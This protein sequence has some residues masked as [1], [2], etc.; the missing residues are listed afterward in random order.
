MLLAK[1]NAAKL[2]AAKIFPVPS[3]RLGVFQGSELKASVTVQ[4]KVLCRVS[5][6]RSQD[7]IRGYA[8]L[9]DA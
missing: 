8:L 5:W 9:P 3:T 7:K 4:T 2:F 6:I 1:V